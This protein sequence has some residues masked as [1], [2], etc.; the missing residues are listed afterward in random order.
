MK[1][2]DLKNSILQLAIQGKLVA[3]DKND[4]PAE[5]LYAKIQAEKQKLI[6][7]GKI[8]K[9]K[10]LPPIT[11]DEIPFP[12]PPSW[13]WVRL[14][15]IEEI[16]LG[17][18]Y[19]P[20]YVSEGI[21]FLSVKNITKGQIDFSNA[22]KISQKTYDEAAYGSKPH[23]GDVLFGRVCSIGNPQIV[24]TEIPFCIFVSLGFLRDHTNILEKK[25]ICVW[26]RS[27][28]FFKQVNENVKGAAQKN[29]NTSCH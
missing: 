21:Y 28:H 6:K 17:F 20:T 11:E 2:Q 25:F 3:Q 18:T 4:E 29:L 15:E 22:K 27:P 16:N 5:V 13:K 8:K 19:K 24:D 7:E 12:I 10:P 9:D 23:K 14:G 26:M 1:A